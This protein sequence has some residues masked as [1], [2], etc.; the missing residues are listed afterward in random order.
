MAAYSFGGAPGQ[1]C[2]THPTRPSG[3]ARPQALSRWRSHFAP[4]AQGRVATGRR[5]HTQACTESAAQVRDAIGFLA[6]LDALLQ[7][8]FAAAALRRATSC[9]PFLRDDGTQAPRLL[10]LL[11]EA[12][13]H[14]TA[15]RPGNDR[16]N[17]R[18]RGVQLLTIYQ[19]LSQL[20]H[21]YGTEWGSIVSNHVC[22]V[23]LPGV[24]DPETLRYFTSTAGQENV[25]VEA[26]SEGR[27]RAGVSAR[28]GVTCS[29]KVCCASCNPAK[30]RSGVSLCPS[31][32]PALPARGATRRHP[33][34]MNSQSLRNVRIR[35]AGAVIP[36]TCPSTLFTSRGPKSR[37]SLELARSSPSKNT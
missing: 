20:R 2:L 7:A 37:E 1:E 6:L 22:K 31:I 36:V 15:A 17:R 23:V 9:S 27:R 10:V 16:M 35:P 14:R 19:D 34:E 21:R 24:T 25:L 18:R 11:D 32:S 33:S 3:G 5:P 30:A 4:G 8:A 28:T 12:A 29:T 26:T 13:K